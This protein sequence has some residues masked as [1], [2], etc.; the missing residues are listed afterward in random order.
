MS[1]QLRVAFAS[2]M[3]VATVEVVSPDMEVVQRFM[4]DAGRS[5]T[6]D[7]PSEASFLRV[8]LPSGQVVTLQDAGNLNREVSMEDIL[9]GSSLRSRGSTQTAAP[10]A[11]TVAAAAPVPALS[12]DDTDPPDTPTQ[13]ELRRYHRVRSMAAPSS[14]GGGQVLPLAQFG[15]ASLIG[16]GGGA[17]PGFSASRNREARW[18]VQS[19]PI[20]PPYQLRIEQPSGAVLQFQLPGTVRNVWARA[21]VLRER[22]AVSYSVRIQTSSHAADTI[23]GYLHR[24]DLYSA[25][26]MA[27]WW[28]EAVGMLQ[29]KMADPYSAV[30]GAYLLL[31]LKR[32]SQMHDWARNLA[33]WFPYLPDG[34]VVWASQLMQQPSSDPAEIRKYLLEAVKRGL[35]V[36]TEGLRLLTDGLRLMG[37]EGVEAREK[38]RAATGVVVWDSPV[39]SAVQTTNA[40]ARNLDTPGVVYDI[41]FAARA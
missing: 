8:H 37:E 14:I 23:A 3:P 31:R 28:D 29:S 15:T 7:V 19:L 13:N 38:I 39:T 10:G 11:P 30:V 40:Y 9:A 34:C 6:V 26:A 18:E 16:P 2:D 21:D 36:Y 33:N 24:G 25:E 4:L 5:R 32:F 17:I 27:E 22:S 35:P 41:A 12:A 1:G 20:H